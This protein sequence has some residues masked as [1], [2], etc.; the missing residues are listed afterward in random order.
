[1][2]YFCEFSREKGVEKSRDIVQAEYSNGLAEKY[3]EKSREK[4]EKLCE[5][6]Q[7]LKDLESSIVPMVE[8]E[9]VP[10]KSISEEPVDSTSQ[11]SDLTDQVGGR[12]LTLIN[13]F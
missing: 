11:M 9:I 5:I 1:M 7:K 8:E 2:C 3:A 4:R 10:K 13:H 12:N 6:E